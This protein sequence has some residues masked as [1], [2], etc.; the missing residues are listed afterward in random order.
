M[1]RKHANTESATFERS[2]S[3][4]RGRY[5][6]FLAVFDDLYPEFPRESQDAGDHDFTLMRVRQN[7]HE[8]TIPPV[9]DIV[10]RLVTDGPLMSSSV[11]C[12]SGRTE[13]CGR[14]GSFY[15]APADAAAEWQS[16]GSH[17][18]LMLAVTR[19]RVLGL[20]SF[21]GTGPTADPLRALYGRDI[22]NSALPHFMEGIWRESIRGGRGAS[23]MVDGLFMTL[24]GTLDRL[25]GEDT[26]RKAKSTGSSMDPA[27]LARVTDYVDANLERTIVIR[28]LADIAGMSPF[29]F[30]RCFRAATNTS[31]HRFVIA[32]RVDL[33]KRLLADPGLPLAQIAFACGFSNQSHF[34]KVFKEHVGV[35]PGTYRAEVT[36]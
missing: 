13:L 35:T 4:R 1:S 36:I 8:K 32:R 17:E 7:G 23:L 22:F 24:L 19:E 25:A 16:E 9:P 33:G 18:L 5:D 11:D 15:I 26:T 29:H 21:D 30:S 14:R 20:L 2:G 3:P 6:S 12:G 34:T 27:R 10:F 31:P 28:E